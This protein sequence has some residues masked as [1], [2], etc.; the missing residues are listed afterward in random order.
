VHFLQARN[1]ANKP[2][3][4]LKRGENEGKKSFQIQSREIRAFA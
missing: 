3:K 4:K 2:H 1:K